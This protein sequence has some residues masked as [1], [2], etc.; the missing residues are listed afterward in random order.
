MSCTIVKNVLLKLLV[1]RHLLAPFHR[2]AGADT[3]TE[4]YTHIHTHRTTTVI[5][6][7]M[8]GKVQLT[9]L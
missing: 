2:V 7:C 3:H 8:H 5:L 1:V 9:V 4:T 6:W